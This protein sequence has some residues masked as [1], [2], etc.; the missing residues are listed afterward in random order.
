MDAGAH[1]RLTAIGKQDTF[2]LS[3]NPDD[4]FFN[5]EPKQHSRFTKY[6]KNYVVYRPNNPPPNWP[7]G[8]DIKVEMKP[9]EMG[10]M[11]SNM[12]IH[13]KVP[14][15]DQDK[16]N[17]HYADQLGR[18]MIES[19]KMRVDD[20]V[21]EEYYDDWG[22]IYDELFLDNSEKRTKRYTLNRSLAEETSI[23]NQTLVYYD[24][25]VFIPIPF[26]FSRKYEGDEHETN[27]PN[28]PYLPLCAMFNQKII[29][30]IKFR[31]QTFFT[32]DT[33]PLT[34]DSFNIL[35]E[36]ITLTPEERM[37]IINTPQTFI[38]DFVKRH[39][40]TE[41]DQN[42]KLE[43]VPKIPVKLLMWFFR[44][45]DFENENDAGNNSGEMS[46]SHFFNRFN[47]SSN[48]SYST[49]NSFFEPIMKSAKIYINN[50]DLPNIQN[51]D[52]TYFKYIMPMSNRLSRPDRNIYTYS[53][54][55]NPINVEP[56][57]SLDFG[58]LQTNR[59]KIEVE[60][61]SNL[62]P[63]NYNMHMYYTGYQ[64]FKFENGFMRRA[65][66]IA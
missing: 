52:H 47:F 17:N 14:K 27:Q 66:E 49:Q 62:S 12:Y 38:S 41:T 53:F 35:N 23:V 18:H 11:L 30:E 25:E 61:E 21:L 16:L 34:L 51:S 32:N 36:E 9:K 39:P 59:T 40:I 31:P 20:L 8:M 4:S 6:Q 48:L 43:L 33:T 54:S 57:G 63:N 37:Y 64:T 29:F 42:T 50:E 19:I 44:N 2:T 45:K 22:I 24:S 65:F 10:D 13:F 46:E 7:F 26:F 15:L 58:T 60:L 28:R 5:Y 1:L 56:S 55:M 3:D